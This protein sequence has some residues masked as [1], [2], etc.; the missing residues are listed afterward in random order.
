M[1][2]KI[3]EVLQYNLKTMS[4]NKEKEAALINDLTSVFEKHG[5][6]ITSSSEYDGQENYCG[7]TIEIMS[8]ER[9]SEGLRDIWFNIGELGR[10]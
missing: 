9:N 7:E 4:K 5:V 3:K 1:Q 8:K 2:D 6:E 10:F